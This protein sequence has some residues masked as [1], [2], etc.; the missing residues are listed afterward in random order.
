MDINRNIKW[1]MKPSVHGIGARHVQVGLIFCLIIVM[2]SI[3][4]A[5]PISIVAMTTPGTSPNPNIPSFPYWNDQSLILISFYWGFAP[6]QLLGGPLARKY[7]YKWFMIASILIASSISLAIPSIVTKFGSQAF[8][9]CL[10]LQG[11]C[12][13]TIVPMF[14]DFISKWAPVD[15]RT[16]L[17]TFI[18]ASKTLGTV[19]ATETAGLLSSSWLGWP[20][21]FY[22]YGSMGLIWC[23]FMG[24]FGS[25]SP[26]QHK[27]ISQAELEFI[28]RG[29]N[30]TKK[31]VPWTHIWWS[32]PTWAAWI[33]QVCVMWTVRLGTTEF[34]TYINRVLGFN[35]S[36]GSTFLA[37]TYLVAY[38]VTFLY[39]GISQ[40]MI[41]NGYLSTGTCRKI[42]N[43]LASWGGSLLLILIATFPSND[44]LGLFLIFLFFI[45]ID[46]SYSG[47][48]INYNDLTPNYAG[49]LL[50]VGGVAATVVSFAPTTLVQF[51]VTD[52]TQASQW[53]HPFWLAAIITSLGNI[54]F[55]WKGEGE[56]QDWDDLGHEDEE[57]RCLLEKQ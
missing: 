45:C 9:G 29:K 26:D 25:S 18:F 33:A 39:S 36:T 16:T 41:V 13:G 15:E 22:L 44:Y 17:G 31:K 42:C 14:S 53:A 35:V 46:A 37:S 50:G 52:Q 2:Y 5:P 19:F 47:F 49:I 8:M 56:V 12:L 27:S 23:F 28:N 55:V 30:F 32:W 24:I 7:G 3:N 43:S 57:S 11:L 21:Q 48:N 51:M 20:S 4:M 10:I 1:N 34:P 6:T 40:Y 38:M 54:I